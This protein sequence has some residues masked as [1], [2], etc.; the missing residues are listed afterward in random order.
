[1]RITF[2]R[3]K[4]KW[5]GRSK[6]CVH[7]R[8]GYQICIP[9]EFLLTCSEIFKGRTKENWATGMQAHSLGPWWSR[10]GTALGSHPHLPTSFSPL[11]RSRAIGG[12]HW[13]TQ[14][15]LSPWSNPINKVYKRRHCTETEPGPLTE[16]GTLASAKLFWM[17]YWALFTINNMK[18]KMEPLRFCSLFYLE[19]L[20][21]INKAPTP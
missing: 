19:F 7:V 6:H 15:S 20:L 21:P 12:L 8:D 3:V 4:E 18:E 2:S 13:K 11:K 16:Y 14:A 10:A 1:M 9:P 5:L 17:E